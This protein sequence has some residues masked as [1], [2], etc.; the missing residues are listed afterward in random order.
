M[1][2]ILNKPL[3]NSLLRA[4]GIILII[5]VCERNTV[6]LLYFPENCAV[7]HQRF[8]ICEVHCP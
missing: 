6:L 1:Q 3:H 2:N 8:K 4:M 7:L 5:F